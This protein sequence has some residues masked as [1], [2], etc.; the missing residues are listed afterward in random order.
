MFMLKYIHG[1]YVQREDNWCNLYLQTKLCNSANCNSF[2]IH[3]LS[4]HSASEATVCAPKPAPSLSLK[5]WSLPCSDNCFSCCR[6]AQPHRA[7]HL[8]QL[9]GV[10]LH[11]ISVWN[12]HVFRHKLTFSMSIYYTYAKNI[13]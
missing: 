9:E 5:H 10:S 12:I 3:R 6:I 2:K 7:T 11:P 13:K 4:S 1:E 8:L